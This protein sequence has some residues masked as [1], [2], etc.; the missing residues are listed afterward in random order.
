MEEYN[1][2]GQTRSL[3]CIRLNCRDA[4]WIYDNCQLGTQVYISP[5]ETDGPLKKPS[6]LQ[7]PSWHTWD[8]TDPTAYYACQQRGCH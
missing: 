3:G 5:T 2:L 6:G 7:L 1:R 8:P 4:K